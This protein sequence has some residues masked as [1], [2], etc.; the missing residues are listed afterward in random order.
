MQLPNVVHPKTINVRGVL[1]QVVSYS[2]LTDQQA[3][4]VVRIFCLDHKLRKK[5]KGKLIQVTTSI[6]A[7]N[8]GMYG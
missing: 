1:F 5:D 4:N 8:A 7:Q 6:D 3:L 2:P